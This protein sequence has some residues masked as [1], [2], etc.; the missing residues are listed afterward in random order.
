VSLQER[1]HYCF[2]NIVSFYSSTTC[3]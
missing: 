2:E 3:G 1:Q